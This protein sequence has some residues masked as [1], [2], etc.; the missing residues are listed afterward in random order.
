MKMDRRK[1]LKTLIAGSI[2]TGA[3]VSG[4]NPENQETT[5]GELAKELP[6]GGG[7]GRTAEEVA[8]DEKIRNSPSSFDEH[9]LATLA[10]LADIILPADENSGSATDAGVI[11]FIDFIVKDMP[12]NLLPT[13][14]AI[15]WV[16]REGN[17]RFEKP[18]KALSQQQQIE[19]I[20]DIAYPFDA[21]PEHQAGA[22]LFSHIRNLVM[23]GY[24]TSEIGIKELGYIGNVT[25]FW[26][27]VPEE[28][29]KKHGMSYDE[30]LADVYIKLENK[31]K[32]AQWDDEGNLV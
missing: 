8:H 23:T 20:E 29:M 24:F 14:S 27:G 2:A 25:T 16:D 11:E 26:D 19:I 31:D 5:T 1:S 22:K 4:C 17:N 21:K 15:G 10:I 28:V 3:A 13:R 18:F 30:S 9:E 7:Y 6:A 32:I 12:Q